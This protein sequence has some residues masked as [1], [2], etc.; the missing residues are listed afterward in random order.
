MISS[1]YFAPCCLQ[2][3]AC[4]I[5]RLVF[6]FVLYVLYFRLWFS[7]IVGCL[8][9]VGVENFRCFIFI[10]PHVYLKHLVGLNLCIHLFIK[11]EQIIL[12]E[13]IVH[14]SS[15]GDLF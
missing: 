4:T 6:R 3:C 2:G 5:W 1:Y 14:C 11:F 12:E 15:Q 9:F 8:L 7:C 10:E 13:R